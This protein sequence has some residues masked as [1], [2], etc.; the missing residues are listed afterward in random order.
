MI[1]RALLLGALLAAAAFG[2]WEV[3]R[4]RTP[5]GRD[6]LSPRQRR[7]R[8]WG[9]FFLLLTLGLWLRGTYL[10]TPAPPGRD[11]ARQEAALRFV[12]YWTVTALCALP[13]LPLALL[14]S[15]E[16]LRRLSDE[17]RRLFRETFAGVDETHADR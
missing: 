7:I 6:L 15:H 14:D 16:N 9:L 8:A 3:R 5:V 13:L 4:W 10:P 11:R 17:R 12:G 1:L 2:L